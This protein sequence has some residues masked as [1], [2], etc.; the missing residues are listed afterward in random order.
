M[1]WTVI[2][3]D[4]LQSVPWRNGQ[5]TLR[6]VLTRLGR[7]GALL[8]QVSIA[9]LVADAPF[10]HYPHC[11]RIF[12]PIAGAP[13]VALAFDDRPFEPCPLLVPRRFAGEREVRCRVTAPG[14]ALNAIA[15]RRHHAVEVTVLRLEAGDAIEAPDAP[16]VVVYCV[17]GELA[18]V[19]DVLRPGDSLFGP[20]PALPGAAACDAV[21][22]L[23]TIAPANP[24]SAAL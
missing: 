23:V 8:W 18:A 13:P 2:R 24:A 19:G 5:G 10:S 15:D 4:S 14:R 9:D 21:A 22:L 11:D 16:E 1:R 20:G 3:N 7:D 6:A 12:T 17:S